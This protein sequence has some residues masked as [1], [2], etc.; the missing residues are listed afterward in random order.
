MSDFKGDLSGINVEN[1]VSDFAGIIDSKYVKK[2]DKLIRGIESKTTIE[3]AVITID[4]LKG[5]SIDKLAFRL[6]NKFGVGKKETNN[7][8]LIL[9]SKNDSKFRIEIGRGLENIVTDDLLENLKDNFIL[10]SFKKK[11]FG[12]G[13]LKFIDA[14]ADKVS[15]GRFSRLSI[16]SLTAGIISGIY[17]IITLLSLLILYLGYR[18]E[19][20]PFGISVVRG[21]ENLMVVSVWWI[22]F[23]VWILII[24][25]SVPAL[26]S[27]IC[28]S[29]D[30]IYIKAGISDTGRKK[31]DIAGIVLGLS[32]VIVIGTFFIPV[33]SQL[34][35]RI[36]G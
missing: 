21:L 29:I 14:V 12:K 15:E 7:G 2:I 5:E 20:Y 24:F 19:I 4:S 31:L 22:Y 9:L 18:Y 28:G 3:V 1:N 25:V 35:S 6:F 13:I 23:S 8:I 16:A 27:I 32:P 26:I 30:F 36:P 17:S 34:I 33:V 10:P 11:K